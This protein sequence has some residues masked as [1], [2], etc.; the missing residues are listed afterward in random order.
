MSSVDDDI[1]LCPHKQVDALNFLWLRFDV[2]TFQLAVL[3]NGVKHDQGILSMLK[4]SP[5]TSLE[6]VDINWE[7]WEKWEKQGEGLKEK[8]KEMEKQYSLE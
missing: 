4:G 8:G 7:K 1:L 5:S 2:S 3:E 6:G